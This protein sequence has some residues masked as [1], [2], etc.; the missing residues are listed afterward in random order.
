MYY[1]RD[2]LGAK[3]GC[4]T[5]GAVLAALFSFFCLL[6]SFGIG[7]MSQVNSI[8]SNVHTAFGIPTI[9]TGIFLLVAVGAGDS[10]RPE[11]SCLHH[12]ESWCP[13]W[14]SCISWAR[15]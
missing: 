14:S 5:I 15:W 12:R 11:A 7:N 2:G 13:L 4:K 6:A 8:V 1:L 9:A 10:G 3:K